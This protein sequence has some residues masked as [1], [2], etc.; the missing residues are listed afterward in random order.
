[1]SVPTREHPAW[2]ALA[3]HQQQVSNLHLR[4]LFAADPGRG[5]RFVAQGAGLYLDYSKNRITDETL[6]LLLALANEC[7]VRAH[8]DAMWRGDK[9]NTTEQRAVLHVALRAPRGEQFIVDG[10]DVASQVHAVLDR[11]ATFTERV[12]NGEWTGHS[13][14]RIRNVVNIGI[15]GSDLGP[16]MTYEALRHYSRRDLQFRFV[17]NVDATDFTEAVRD[18]DPAQTLFVV[19]SKTFTTQETLANARAARAWLVGRLGEESVRNHFVAVSTNAVEVAKFGIDTA[20]MFGFWDWVGGRYSMDSAI[21]LS[22]MLAIGAENF[23]ALLAGFHAMDEHFRTVP[24]AQNLP[25]LLALLSIWYTDFFGAE[26]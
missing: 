9:I 22:T 17:S 7:D 14:E 2:K 3:L 5:E 13:G 4:D 23:R 26:S 12:R 11:M 19:C 8:I 24:F 10:V 16:V 25:V 18:L 15:G 6:Q 20:N 1:M 21:G